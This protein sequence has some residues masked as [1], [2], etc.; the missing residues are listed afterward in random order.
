MGNT[1]W[2]EVDLYVRF[3]HT[4]GHTDNNFIVPRDKEMH[5]NKLFRSFL[6]GTPRAAHDV[7]GW[8]RALRTIGVIALL[9]MS[10][11][12]GA[13]AAT[14][15]APGPAGGGDYEIGPE[16]VLDISVW[17]EKDLQREVLVRPDGWLTFPLVGNVEAAGKTPQQLENEIR[18][19]LRKFIPEPVV[20]VTVK[21]IQ[22]LKIF[23]IGRVGKPGEYM[24][25]RYVDIL[26]ALTLAGGLTPFAKEDKIKVVRKKGGKEIIIP[27]D[28]SEVKK[29]KRLEQNITLRSGDVIVVP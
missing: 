8:R 28:Y 23:V 26:Q 21:K 19:R 7:R 18:Q 10:P 24:V 15:A 3:E 12:L 1:D 9:V 16:D 25:G 11:A 14:P 13:F 20:T 2:R 17:R 4:F 6:S 22:G 29:G 27:F 5:T